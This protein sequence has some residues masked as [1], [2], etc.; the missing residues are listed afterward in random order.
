MSNSAI[1][2]LK[3]SIE[4]L[5]ER[6]LDDND[7]DSIDWLRG[8]S[9]IVDAMATN[10]NADIFVNA[11]DGFNKR[12]A[13]IDRLRSDLA[14][15]NA[16]VAELGAATKPEEPPKALVDWVN[17]VLSEYTGLINSESELLSILYDVDLLPEQVATVLRVNP[18]AA[19]PN[20]TRMSAICE[21]WKR[22]TAA[23]TRLARQR[24]VIEVMDAALA[25][26]AEQHRKSAEQFKFYA[27]QHMAKRPPDAER[28]LTNSN[29]AAR[30]EIAAEDVCAARAAMEGEAGG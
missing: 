17:E 26:S 11:I 30:C 12:D 19:G 21:L 4:G 2:P 9:M 29:H 24:A 18:R 3:S 14:A 28:A 27:D 25:E 22:N 15:S 16:R 13:E 7:Q 6:S 10:T 23:N 8:I 1:E 5:L 20:A